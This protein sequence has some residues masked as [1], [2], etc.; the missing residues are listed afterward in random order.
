MLLVKTVRI[1]KNPRLLFA[2][3][4]SGGEI[5]GPSSLIK[6]KGGRIAISMREKS[7]GEAI[8]ITAAMANWLAKK[9]ISMSD[10]LWT[11]YEENQIRSRYEIRLDKKYYNESEPDIEKLYASKRVGIGIR[12]KNDMFF[13]SLALGFKDGLINLAHIKQ[14]LSETFTEL[15]FNDL[16]DVK[17]VGD[18]TYF[19]FSEKYLEVRPSGTDAMNKAYCY[20]I[21]LWECIKYAKQFSEFEGVRTSLHS[22]LISDKYY[23]TI[24]EYAYENYVKY[25]E[26]M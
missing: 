17:F 21:D 7:A 20:G 25:K 4:E 11:I 26:N 3:E 19:V 1:G 2:G 12:T 14:I 16:L 9:S 22:K 13:L 10:Y 24:K 8:I 6:S 23:D 5:F 15:N 18:G